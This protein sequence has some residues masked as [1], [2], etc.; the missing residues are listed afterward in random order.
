MRYVLV[1]ILLSACAQPQKGETGASGAPGM[2]GIPGLP[3][4][5][6]QGCDVTTLAPSHD[7]PT[8]G[9]L[10]SCGVNSVIVVNGASG[11]NGAASYVIIGSID[12]CGPS[13]GQDEIFLL[14]ASGALVA[15]Y[16]D[17]SSALTARLSYIRDGVGYTTTDNSGCQFNLTTDINGLRTI[18]YTTAVASGT[19]TSQSWQT[20]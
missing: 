16:V 20:Y 1:L 6:G 3:G 19:P 10:I 4:L 2:P 15:L 18:Q 8:G 7:T 17:N 5:P 9:A 12:P 11:A 14:M 13:G